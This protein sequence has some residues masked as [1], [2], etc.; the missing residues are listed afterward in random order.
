[1]DYIRDDDLKREVRSLYALGL[2]ADP[3]DYEAERNLRRRLYPL[4]FAAR[5][6]R[7][8]RAAL[9]AKRAREM[10]GEASFGCGVTPHPARAGH[11]PAPDGSPDCGQEDPAPSAGGAP[12]PTTLKGAEDCWAGATL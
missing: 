12:A 9:A 5:Q 11:G 6:W 7:T 2:D 3:L 10:R 4:A 1:M 8:C